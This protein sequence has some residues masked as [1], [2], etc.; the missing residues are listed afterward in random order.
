LDELEVTVAEDQPDVIL[1]TEMWCN[2]EMNNAELQ[3]DRYQL[4][5]D[6]RKDRCDTTNG[7]GGG[8]LVYTKLG[9]EIRPAQSFNDINFNQYCA[10]KLMT[11]K[12]IKIVLVY[13]PPNSG[14]INTEELCKLLSKVE[15]DTILVGDFNFPEINWSQLST[16][17]RS[18]EFIDTVNAMQLDQLVHF[19]THDRGNTLDLVLTNCS[20]RIRNVVDGGKLSRSDHSIINITVSAQF[21]AKKPKKYRYL[22]NKANFTAIRNELANKFWRYNNSTSVEDDWQEV[23]MALIDMT[24]KC[25]LD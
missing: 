23:K 14:Q 3:L 19:P 20:D 24:E 17:N 18:Q 25:Y 16:T 9:I 21:K 15:G 22:W 7:I 11:S 6:C 2:T 1:L 12:P 4:E 5:V 8:L 13:R 10:F